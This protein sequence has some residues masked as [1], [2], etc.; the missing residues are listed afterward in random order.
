MQ[1]TAEK[2]LAKKR[3]YFHQLLLALGEAQYKEVIVAERF[4]NIVHTTE[5]NGAQL[6]TLINEA[7]G[8]LHKARKAKQ[9]VELHEVKALKKWRNKCLLVLN[10]RGIIA[11][12][13]NWAPINDELSKKQY[14]WV[15]SADQRNK[16]LINNKGL[17]AFNTEEDLKKLFKQLVA[18]RD[19]EKIQ[20]EKE[21][22]LANKN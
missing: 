9:E 6:T 4:E 11:T 16:G 18:I 21:T 13:K 15:L 17:Y 14:Q 7:R 1:T 3:Q 5:L 2:Q 19:A 22:R 8:R 12:P 20:K 10:E